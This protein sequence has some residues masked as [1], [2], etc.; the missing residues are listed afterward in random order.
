MS[1]SVLPP[2]R[3]ESTCSTALVAALPALRWSDTTPL[4]VSG[5]GPCAIGAGA[6][7][8]GARTRLR[9]LARPFVPPLHVSHRLRKTTG[10]VNYFRQS[11]GNTS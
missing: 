11:S 10:V 8:S 6:T 4:A 5:P 1:A 3:G 7:G 9:H 2:A